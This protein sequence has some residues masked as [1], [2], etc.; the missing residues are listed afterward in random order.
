MRWCRSF[1]YIPAP[2]DGGGILFYLCPSHNISV[3]FFSVTIDDTNLIF[4]HKLHI[5]MPYRGSD[6]GPVRFLLLV[7][8]L[9]LFL[10]TLNIISK[11]VVTFFS[12]TIDGTNIIL[13]HK[14]HIQCRYAIL[15]EAISDPW[16]SYLPFADVWRTGVS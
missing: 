3:T 14:L 15:W 8:R 1:F 2:P 9:S 6:F 10:Y 16:G 12:A 13:Y 4:G 5:G 7:C 11:F